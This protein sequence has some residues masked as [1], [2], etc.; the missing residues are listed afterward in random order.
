[1]SQNEVIDRILCS[2]LFEEFYP[3]R[4]IFTQSKVVADPEDLPDNGCLLLWGGEDISP[5]LYGEKPGSRTGASE[6]LSKR[7]QYEVALVIAAIK[8]GLPIIGICRGAQLMCALAG[9]KVIQHVNGHAVGKD[10]EIYTVDHET[11]LTTSLHHQM[12][13]PFDTNHQVI[14]YANPQLSEVY[15]GEDDRPID[16]PEDLHVDEWFKIEPEIVWFPDV[17]CLAIQGHPEFM[18]FNKPFVQYCRNLVEEYCGS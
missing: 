10:H 8:K 1:M 6:I 18:G 12:M 2:A 16:M 15:L 13:Y 17:K 14:A 11:Y 5:S 9:G 7:D 3:F 4:D